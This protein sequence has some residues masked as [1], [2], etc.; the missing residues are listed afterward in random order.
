MDVATWINFQR[1][2]LSEKSQSKQ[3][4][5]CIIPFKV[6]EMKKYI[7]IYTEMKDRFWPPKIKKQ[8]GLRGKQYC[9]KSLHEEF[10]FNHFLFT[11]LVKDRFLPWGYGD[12]QTPNIQSW[13]SEIKRSLSVSCSQ[14]PEKEDTAPHS[15]TQPLHWKTEWTTKGC[16]RLLWYREFWTT[17][18][19][20]VDMWLA[21]LNK[22][23][24]AREPK[25]TA[26]G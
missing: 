14:S 15:P 12:G 7:Y 16:R 25:L 8:M 9:Y 2:T 22:S 5:H 4:I 17:L 1:I 18:R 3:I 13:T 10:Y 20:N 23:T 24:G 6:L 19:S 11:P 26:Q 21:Y